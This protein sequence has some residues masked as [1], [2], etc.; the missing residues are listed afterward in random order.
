MR[1]PPAA[2][3]GRHGIFVVMQ[4][5]VI[6]KL[7]NEGNLTRKLTCPGFQKSQWCGIGITPRLDRELIVVVRIVTGWVRRK[8]PCRTMLESLVYRQNDQFAGPGQLAGP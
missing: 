2:R 8:T 1:I 3:D 6:V 4:H 7:E 5:V